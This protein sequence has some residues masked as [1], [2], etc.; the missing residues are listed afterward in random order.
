M[1]APGE[2]KVFTTYPDCSAFVSCAIQV[3]LVNAGQ[4]PAPRSPFLIERLASAGRSILAN[5]CLRNP[6]Y[7]DSEQ[8]VI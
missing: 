1:T 8:N 2:A 6:S 3:F 5:R 7:P 4:V